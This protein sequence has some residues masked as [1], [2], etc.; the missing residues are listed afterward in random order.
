[1][2]DFCHPCLVLQL[3]EA[4]QQ[5]P[6]WTEEWHGAMP[7]PCRWARSIRYNVEVDQNEH[8]DDFALTDAEK[9]W[10]SMEG[11]YLEVTFS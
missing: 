2:P 9:G 4:R 7:V 10:E 5:R 1:M 8:V 3:A 11:P 6:H